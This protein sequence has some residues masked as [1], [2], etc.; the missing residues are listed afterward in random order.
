MSGSLLRE[1]KDYMASIG[2]ACEGHTGG[3]HIKWTLP[4]GSAYY[5]ALSPSDQR[6]LRNIKADCRRKLGLA[7]DGGKNAAK[8][9]NKAEGSGFSIE[10]AKRDQRHSAAVREVITRATANVI[11]LDAL[12]IEAQRRR[13][14][15]GARPLIEQ[16]MASMETLKRYYQPIPELRCKLAA[17]TE[18]AAA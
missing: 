13:D 10:A 5:T 4:D 15:A 1:V 17:V 14:V 2:A 12:L 6:V 7:H 16:L 18:A 9:S 3:D 8:Y 11:R